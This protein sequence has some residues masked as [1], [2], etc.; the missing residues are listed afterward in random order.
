MK[1]IQCHKPGGSLPHSNLG[2]TGLFPGQQMV[3]LLKETDI[4]IGT[5]SKYFG[6]IL[7]IFRSKKYHTDSFHII[8]YQANSRLIQPF[9]D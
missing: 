3:V 8:H 1:T 7:Q 9:Y 4:S 6:F 5:I 2:G